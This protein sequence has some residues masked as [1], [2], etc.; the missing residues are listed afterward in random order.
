[1]EDAF[2]PS[3]ADLSRINPAQQLYISKV[4]HKTFLKVDEEGT[5]AAAVTAIGVETTSI[6][7]PTIFRAD[8]PFVLMIRERHSGSI[9]FA[10][11]VMHL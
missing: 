4:I 2:D 3:R 10:G 8:R 11:K 6:T 9:I 1:M 7:E 5:E